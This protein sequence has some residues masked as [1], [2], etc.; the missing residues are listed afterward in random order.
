[1]HEDYY[2]KLLPFLITYSFFF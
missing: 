1:M 2:L